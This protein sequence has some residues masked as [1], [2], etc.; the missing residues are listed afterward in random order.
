MNKEILKRYFS[1]QS[2]L[3]EKKQ[4]LEYFEGED[5]QVFDEYMLEQQENTEGISDVKVT[6]KDDFYKELSN[7][8]RLCYDEAI[9]RKAFKICC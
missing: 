2:S 8:L 5:M 3:W 9:V 7:L 1:G 4:V 6:Y